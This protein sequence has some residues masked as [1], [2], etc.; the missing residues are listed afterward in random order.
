M[1]ATRGHAV[2]AMTYTCVRCLGHGNPTWACI[3]SHDLPHEWVAKAVACTHAR[4]L[5]HSSLVW[6]R[7]RDHGVGPKGLKT[8]AHF[9]SGLRP[10]PK[11][12]NCPMTNEGNSDYQD[13]LPRTTLS[14]ADQNCRR[15]RRHIT[16]DN[17][18]EDP[19]GDSE[20][21]GSTIGA[22]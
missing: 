18:L 22:W 1:A 16:R 21:N 13:T 20:S 2:D 3:Q 19:K 17:P 6:A 4:Y 7:G 5:S 10:M 8:P 14:S 15:G 11:R 12:K 9:I